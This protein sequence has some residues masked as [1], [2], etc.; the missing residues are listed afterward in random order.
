MNELDNPEDKMQEQILFPI[1]LRNL[2]LRH[3]IGRLKHEKG[4][5]TQ[6]PKRDEEREL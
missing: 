3:S 1:Q 6:N 2:Y 5:L 4:R